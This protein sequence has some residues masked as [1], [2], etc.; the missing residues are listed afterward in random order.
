[1][2]AMV[3]VPTYDP[4]ALNSAGDALFSDP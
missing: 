2:L 3:S 4:G 1:M